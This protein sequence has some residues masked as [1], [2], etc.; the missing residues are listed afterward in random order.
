MKYLDL[1]LSSPQANLACD[2]ALLDWCEAGKT[3]E[4]LRV[5]ESDRPF[6]VLGYGNEMAREVDVPLCRKRDVPV[7]RRCSG[8]GAV[9]QGPGCLSYALIL[10]VERRPELGSVTGTNRSIM[11]KLRQMFGN[12]LEGDVQVQ[13]HT[14]L[15]L[16]NRKFSGNAQRRRRHCLLFHGTFLLNFDLGLVHELLPLPSKQPAYRAQRPHREFL[17]NAG[18]APTRVKEALMESWQAE[19]RACEWPAKMVQ[20][21]VQAKYSQDQWNLR[22]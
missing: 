13:G 9:V 12:L 22:C 18:L 17:R 19:D 20:S 5:W 16:D 10:R 15:V 11:G 7:L 1:T 6:V 3:D 2:E 8:G 4:V 21:L 14:D